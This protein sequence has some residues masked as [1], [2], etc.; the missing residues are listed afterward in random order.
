MHSMLCARI[1]TAFMMPKYEKMR[2]EV[3]KV[4]LAMNLLYKEPQVGPY[5]PHAKFEERLQQYSKNILELKNNQLIDC[6]AFGDSI[7]DGY[8]NRWE[9]VEDKM[10]F[11]L[12]G[13]WSHHMK[14]MA[15]AVKPLF[16]AK[17]IIPKN[18]IIGT[19]GG[20]PLLVHQEINSVI[21]QATE[22]LGTLRG[23]WPASRIIV[24]GLPPVIAT[25]ATLHSLEFEKG[26]Y[27][28]VLNDI[29]SVF[30]PMQKGFAGKWGIFPKTYM[31]SDGVHLSPVG[32]ILLDERFIKGKTAIPKSIID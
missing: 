16:D 5:V 8:R 2:K 31:T 22:T 14:Q 1:E 9:A 29:N 4:D 30:I 6:I 28:W 23:M 3:Q 17:R 13:M 7:I 20:N 21:Q 25:Y 18:I 27:N 11:A 26:V 12:W 32:Q 19:L 10:N 15:C 24:Y